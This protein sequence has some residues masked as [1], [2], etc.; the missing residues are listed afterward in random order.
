MLDD[1]FAVILDYSNRPR[2]PQVQTV[3]VFLRGLAIEVGRDYKVGNGLN[4]LLHHHCH[5]QQRHQSLSSSDRHCHLYHRQHL[6]FGHCH[7]CHY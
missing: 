4:N 5:Q 2:Q 7:H 3:L 1:R 6:C